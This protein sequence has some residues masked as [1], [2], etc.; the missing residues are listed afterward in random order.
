MRLKSFS[1][2]IILVLSFLVAACGNSDSK[3][4]DDSN[5]KDQEKVDVTIQLAW[6][7]EYSS[8]PFYS[9][10]ENGRFEDA[11]LNVTLITGGFNE[12]GYVDPIAQVVSGDGDFGLSGTSSMLEERANGQSVV[13][14][15]TVLQRSPFSLISLSDSNIN[16]PADL[17]GKTI[18]VTEGTAQRSLDALLLAEGISPDDVTIVPRTS[19]GI[20]PLIDGDV[21][22]LGGWIINEGIQIQEAGFEPTFILLSDYGIDEYSFTVFTTEEM[23]NTQPE[24]VNAVVDSIVKGMEDT[25]ANPE[26]AIDY[27]LK[28]APEL[29]REE[30]QTRLYAMLPLM[31]IP[32]TALGLMDGNIWESNNQLLLDN[33]VIDSEIE[34]RKS[35]V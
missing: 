12:D 4:N 19:F 2:S 5:T 13:S 11:N 35:V 34:D 28:F 23:I 14:V 3:D 10:I 33:S 9:A 6:T 17:V 32:N 26:Q 29:N 25:I 27:V 15:L 20:D 7:H 1:L 16:T 22:V 30:Q 8:A 24:V 21:D 18:T 31:N